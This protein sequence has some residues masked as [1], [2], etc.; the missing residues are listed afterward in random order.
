MVI[1]QILKIPYILN[2]FTKKISSAISEGFNCKIK[3]LKR[4]AYE[5]RDIYYFRLKIHQHYGYLNP[6]RFHFIQE[7]TTITLELLQ[8]VAK[9]VQYGEQNIN[10]LFERLGIG[11][12]LLNKELSQSIF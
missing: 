1:K 7:R 4:M 5:Y 9:L 11:N 10:V 6:R 8:K 2:W 12:I 3:R